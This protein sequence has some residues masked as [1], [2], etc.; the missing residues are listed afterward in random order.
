MA[1]SEKKDLYEILG[2]DKGADDETIKKAY[3]SMA[4]KYHP[5]LNPG[6]P[7]AE[8]KFKEVNDAY[9]ILSDPQKK[10]AYDQYGYSAFDG[11]MGAGGG[12]A[13][14]GGFTDFGDLGDIFGSF[15]GGFS[16]FGGQQ[17][18]NGP[19]RGDDIGISVT[20]EFREA[21]AGVKKDVSYSR[22]CS[23]EACGGSGSKDGRSEKCSACRGTGR[24][25]V[26]QKLG[27]MS[28]QSTATCDACGG[29]GKIIK[30]PCDKCRGSGLYRKTEKL[31]VSIPAGIDDG[32][33]M[34]V[35]GKGNGGLNGGES[36]DLIVEVRVKKDQVFMR[37]GTTLLCD[38]PITISDAVLGADIEVPTLEGPRSY[39][40]P[41]G[42]QSGTRFT[43]RGFGLP[44]VRSQRKGDLV[45]T[46]VVEIP[47]GL[48]SKQKS[49]MKDFA[50][51]C[52]EGN[53]EKRSRFRNIFKR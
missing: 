40:I 28:F 26:V 10:A 50:A 19:R 16:G 29:T 4:K 13:G 25:T 6:D 27:G 37:D 12:G 38:V 7:T 42:T 43:L 1:D 49:I 8:A 32:N 36:G 11:S 22:V 33:R 20:V 5:D 23:C 9:S 2:I 45:F 35:S 24:R 39:K 47:K 46:V 18:R 48:N 53:Y 30:N 34:V 17:R 15:F 51:A 3:R 44:G 21:A 31:T 14:F 52:G 41:E